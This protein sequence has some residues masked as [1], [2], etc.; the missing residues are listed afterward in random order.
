M[1]GMMCPMMGSDMEP[2]VTVADGQVDPK[3]IE[4]MLE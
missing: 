3:A 4:R 2:M 1:K